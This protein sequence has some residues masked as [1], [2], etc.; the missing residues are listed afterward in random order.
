MMVS[1]DCQL[2][3]LCSHLGDEPWGMTVR[4]TIGSMLVDVGRF[5][6]VVSGTIL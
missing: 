4:G 6:S 1:V 5:I 3:R 2:G